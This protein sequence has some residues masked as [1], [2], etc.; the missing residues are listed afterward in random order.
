LLVTAL[1]ALW[2]ATGLLSGDIVPAAADRRDDVQVAYRT[3]LPS[4]VFIEGRSVDDEIAVSGRLGGGSFAVTSSAPIELVGPIARRRCELSGQARA[5]CGSR[6]FEYLALFG[7]EGDDRLTSKLR[8]NVSLQGDLGDDLLR[9]PTTGNDLLGGRGVDNLVGG[10]GGDFL[11]GGAGADNLSGGRG[12]DDVGAND[13][14]RDISVRC[15]SGG[16][17]FLTRDP[18][19]PPQFGC[20]RVETYR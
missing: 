6:G 14:D 17:D 4:Y 10:D 8:G 20:E 2:L 9:S 18:E 3:E 19:D 15:G 12:E 16:D 7:H 11:S 13:G 1:P 5:R